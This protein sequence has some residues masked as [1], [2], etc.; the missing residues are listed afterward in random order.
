MSGGIATPS[1]CTSWCTRQAGV[2]KEGLQ[3]G[4]LRG[5]LTFHLRAAPSAPNMTYWESAQMATF[6]MGRSLKPG[7]ATISS[8]VLSVCLYCGG[9][10][11]AILVPASMVMTYPTTYPTLG[12]FSEEPS[13]KTN[14]YSCASKSCSTSGD[15]FTAVILHSLHSPRLAGLENG[16]EGGACVAGQADADGPV[17]SSDVS[18]RTNCTDWSCFN[19]VL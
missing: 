12:S 8:S 7:Q 5:S 2:H 6:L 13:V 4:L 14:R 16:G 18:M 19:V 17:D 3:P 9:T 10:K 1:P 15:S 11:P